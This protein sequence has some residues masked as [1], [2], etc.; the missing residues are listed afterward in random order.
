MLSTSIGS[1]T[2]PRRNISRQPRVTFRRPPSIFLFEFIRF[3]E[4]VSVVEQEKGEKADQ[5]PE[6]WTENS[7]P[8]RNIPVSA[9]GERD[10]ARESFCNSSHK[11]YPFMVRTTRNRTLPLCI[12][13]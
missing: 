12:C 7:E 10:F 6:H 5:D 8:K 11:L 2:R 13:S 3:F 1:C 4:F 9:S